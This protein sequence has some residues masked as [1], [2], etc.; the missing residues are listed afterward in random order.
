LQ[1]A[2]FQFAGLGALSQHYE[3]QE[4]GASHEIERRGQP[5]EQVEPQ[6]QTTYHE[7]AAAAAAQPLVLIRGSRQREQEDVVV[8][9]H[10]LR[11]M[12]MG[13]RKEKGQRADDRLG[14]GEVELPEEP[15]A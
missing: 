4:A 3:Q 8:F 7:R 14:L 12:Q 9:A 11:V 13:G 5:G 10:V 2:V 1:G 15:A 6:R